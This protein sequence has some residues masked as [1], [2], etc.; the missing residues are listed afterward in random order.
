MQTMAGLITFLKKYNVE[1]AEGTPEKLEFEATTML[2]IPI[3]G[4]NLKVTPRDGW[5]KRMYNR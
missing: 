5:E 4:L 2:T 1:L 3:C